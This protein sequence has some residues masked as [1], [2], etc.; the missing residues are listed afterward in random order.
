MKEEDEKR[1]QEQRNIWVATVRPDGRPHMT[2]VWFAFWMGRIYICISSRSV[3][4]RN[5]ESS[6]EI[7]VALEN[8]NTPLIVE[9]E[10]E[11]V[12]DPWPGEVA[13]IFQR[14]YNWDINSDADYDLLVRIHP[15]KW[16]AW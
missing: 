9:G 12:L 15:R 5:L 4:A 8:G 6:A 14:K 13:A 11:L 10:A 2:P 16:L 7:A 3:K 1:L